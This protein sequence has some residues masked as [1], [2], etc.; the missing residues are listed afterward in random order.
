MSR[1][2]IDLDVFGQ[3]PLRCGGYGDVDHLG[4]K[5]HGDLISLVRDIIEGRPL[6]DYSPTQPIMT[7][8]GRFFLRTRGRL[9][10][11]EKRE[12]KGRLT[13]EEIGNR[14][15]WIDANALLSDQAIEALA[16][17][18]IKVSERRKEEAGG[19]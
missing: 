8:P 17:F 13:S 2:R 12:W 9:K 3:G 4:H 7:S 19:E 1:A 15:T 5:E 10:R 18:L 11:V 14:M 6:E 16:D